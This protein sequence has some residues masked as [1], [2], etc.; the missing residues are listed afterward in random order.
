MP[1]LISMIVVGMKLP[2]IIFVAAG[3]AARFNETKT[4]IPLKERGANKPSPYPP[5]LGKKSEK[6]VE[7]ISLYIL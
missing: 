1:L 5:I 7:F 3:F 4:P 2:A 6:Q